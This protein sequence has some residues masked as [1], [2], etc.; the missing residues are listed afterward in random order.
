MK[1]LKNIPLSEPYFFGKE[2]SFLNDCIK[3]GWITTS[4]KY[5]SKFEIAIKKITKAKYCYALVN[6]TSCLQLAIKA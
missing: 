3:S 4:G 2:K 6:C 5:L 1:R